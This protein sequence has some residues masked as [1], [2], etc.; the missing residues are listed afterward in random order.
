MPNT[1]FDALM[2]SGEDALQNHGI[3]SLII[4]TLPIAGF[5]VENLNLRVTNFA[6]PEL[7]IDTYEI[8]KRGK[9]FER[10]SGVSGMTKDFQF[11]YRI[12]RYYTTYNALTAWMGLIQNPVT[13]TMASDAGLNGTGGISTYRA[14]VNITALDTNNN[15]LNAW[16]YMGCFPKTHDAIEFDETSGDPITA[17]CTMSYV[18][19]F[20]PGIPE[21]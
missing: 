21:K 7:T 15:L 2:V 1:Y 4:P 12:D 19:I 3:F 20:F 18:D 11:T 13:L 8:V 5:P 16:S 17:S 14:P 6:I 10:P 9:K